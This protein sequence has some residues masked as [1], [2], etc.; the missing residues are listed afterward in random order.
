MNINDLFTFETG[1]LDAL[2]KTDDGNIPLVYGTSENNGVVK[3]VSVENNELIFTP[4]L[5]TVSY[6]GSAFV[7]TVPFSTSVVD[8]SN[9]VILRPIKKCH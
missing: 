4:P 7:Q 2:E 9:I 3:F 8:K 5:I 1:K 6:L